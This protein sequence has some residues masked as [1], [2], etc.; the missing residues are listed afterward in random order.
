MRFLTY[1]FI[2]FLLVLTGCDKDNQVKFDLQKSEELSIP[3]LKTA[4]Q[5]PGLYEPDF[6][7]QGSKEFENNNTNAS[8][9]QT[10]TLKTLNLQ[11]VDPPQ[12]DFSFVESI[13]VYVDGQDSEEQRIAYKVNIRESIGSQ[14]ALKI[15]N[16]DLAPYLDKE[17]FKMRYDVAFD[18]GTSGKIKVAANMVFDV[19]AEVIE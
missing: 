7:V 18:E 1:I 14:L 11:I 16:L 6:R 4:M 5:L 2:G 17:S 8:H 12:R 15:E 9:V 19:R 10:M 13:H 3:E